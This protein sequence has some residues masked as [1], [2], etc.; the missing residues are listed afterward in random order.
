MAANA[1]RKLL[2]LTNCVLQLNLGDDDG[3][4]SE[5]EEVEEVVAVKV[6][7]SAR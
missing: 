1:P 3:E 2:E 5:E 7:H 4:D 6:G